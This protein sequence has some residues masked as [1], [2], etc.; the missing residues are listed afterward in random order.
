MVRADGETNVVW[1]LTGVI[2]ISEVWKIL[3]KSAAFVY[4]LSELQMWCSM[5]HSEVSLV[6]IGFF[7]LNKIQL[8]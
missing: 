1:S 8:I 2:H 6:L 4:L 5:L 7:T 3:S